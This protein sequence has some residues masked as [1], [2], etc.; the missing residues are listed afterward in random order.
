MFKKFG[1]AC[2]LLLS[3][4]LATPAMADHTVCLLRHAEKVSGQ[5]D[6]T[7]TGNGKDALQMSQ[8]CLKRPALQAFLF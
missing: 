5:S 3:M 2:S 7:L 6:G 8:P 4:V 1:L